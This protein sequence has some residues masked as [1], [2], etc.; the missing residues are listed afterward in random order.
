MFDFIQKKAANLRS[1]VDNCP[2]F[3][4]FGNENEILV[5]SGTRESVK[6]KIQ[7]TGHFLLQKRFICKFTIDG[8]EIEAKATLLGDTFTCDAV[9]FTTTSPE[10]TVKFDIL[11][12]KTK[13][14]ANPNNVH[15]KFY[16]IEMLEVSEFLC[17]RNL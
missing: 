4:A 8:H 15:C 14:L 1:G 5:P 3:T 7:V 11:Y 2:K 9:E 6:A 16:S 10:T 12:E 17:C 13:A